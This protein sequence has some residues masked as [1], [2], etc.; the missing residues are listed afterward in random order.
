VNLRLAPEHLRFRISESELA[1][2]AAGGPLDAAITVA[3]ALRL[4]YQIRTVATAQSPRGQTM[5]LSSSYAN[6]AMC[7]V[8]TVFGDGLHQLKSGLAGKDGIRES[9]AFAN[10]EM[11]TV[12]LEI[13]L[14]S[15]K[16]AD[17]S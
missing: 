5:N 16:G 6:G 11:L 2:L 4:E 12:G 10:G 1:T 8:L 9:L 7:L 3:D 14:H 17:K 15:K 13:D